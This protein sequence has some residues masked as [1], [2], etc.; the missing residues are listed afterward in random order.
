[1]KKYVYIAAGGML[2]ALARYGIKASDWFP[3]Q[4]DFPFNTLI[5]NLLGCFLIALILTAATDRLEIGPDL[6]IGITS[7]FIG[8]FTTFSALCRETFQVFADG[9]YAVGFL[10]VAASFLMGFGSIL[11]GVTVAHCVFGGKPGTGKIAE[12]EKGGEPV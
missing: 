10:Y 12:N 4:W 9:R 3:A 11:L 6:R 1:M 7:G 8:A 5:T 2:G